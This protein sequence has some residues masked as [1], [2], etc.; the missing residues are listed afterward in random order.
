MSTNNSETTSHSERR[1]FLKTISAASALAFSSSIIPEFAAAQAN[2][3]TGTKEKTKVKS[4]KK[5]FWPNGARMVVAAG[6]RVAVHLRFKGHFTGLFDAT[7]GTG[8]EVNFQAFDLYRVKNGKIVD[9]W[10]LEDNL[11]FLKQIGVIK[12]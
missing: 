12:K 4:K 9:N 7:Q 1:E 2:Q 3:G 5:D 11:T 10:H 6:D 8:Q